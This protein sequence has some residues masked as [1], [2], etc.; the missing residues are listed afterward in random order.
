[1]DLIANS[2]LA[3]YGIAGLILFAVAWLLKEQ[4]LTFVKPDGRANS[5]EVEDVLEK[6]T[7]AVIVL[8]EQFRE[9]NEHFKDNNRYFGALDAR[10]ISIEK[11]LN[12][13]V[14]IMTEMRFDYI[15]NSKG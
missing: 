6:T 9:T 7:K 4:I 8:S 11:N 2:P 12:D 15:R 3:N 10:V 1:M 5:S 14:R 13:I